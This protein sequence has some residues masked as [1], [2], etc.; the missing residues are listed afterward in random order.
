MTTRS[1]LQTL[2]TMPS[3][4]F[5]APLDTSELAVYLRDQYDTDAEKARNE[6][7]ALRDELYRDGGCNYMV[8]VIDK[9]YRDDTVRELRKQWVPFARFNNA[10][11]RIVKDLSTVY[12]EPARRTVD[13]D[14]EKY[15]DVLKRFGMDERMIE[16][17]RLFNL[18]RT[19]LVRP[20]VRIDDAG[21][22][23]LVL[24]I[25]TPASVRAVM[26]PNDNTLVIGWLVRTAYRPARRVDS[27]PAWT[28]W[29]KHEV[30]LLDDRFHIIAGTYKE[31]GIG[32]NP[33]VPLTAH[34]SMP[35]FW[36][37][38]EGEDLVAATV[39]IWF[40]GVSLLKET[41]SATKQPIIQGDMT[42]ASRQQ[43]MDSE[44]PAELPEGTAVTT[45]DMSMDLSLFTGTADHVLERAANNYGMSMAQVTHQGVQSAE[46]RELM[47]VPLRELR[48]EQQ[49]PF[50]KFEFN[51]ALAMA[52]VLKKDWPELAFDPT[53]WRIDFGE[54]Q[55]PL[56]GMDRL[57]IF[58]KARTA[59]LDNTVAYL[60]RLNPDLTEDQARDI[61]AQN[62]EIETWRNELM[63]PL[64]EISGSLGADVPGAPPDE[65]APNDGQ[66]EAPQ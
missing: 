38:E 22:R 57:V 3:G 37:G 27:V 14:D 24:D 17:N 50:R 49:T 26:H 48:L 58:E 66:Q 23:S 39:T 29:T 46:A 4:T 28:L 18:H 12:T 63:R 5:E 36:P 43:V 7:H 54:P 55:T 21:E 11:K 33:W 41:K 19:L 35:G 40:S 16:I 10:I 31:H 2:A 32:L 51:L 62:I 13:N 61:I 64:Q 8:S 30:A 9:V 42:T 60:L 34:E 47:R 65:E 52:A 25:A 20:R 1:I 45:V 53:G 15:Q 44:V 56:S 59:G 6:R